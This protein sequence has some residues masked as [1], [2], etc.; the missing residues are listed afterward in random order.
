MRQNLNA[1]NEQT[2]D[3]RTSIRTRATT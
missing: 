3:I 1:V 2:D